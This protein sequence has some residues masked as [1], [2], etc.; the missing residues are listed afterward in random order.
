MT[1]PPIGW[2]RLFYPWLDSTMNVGRALAAAGWP[3][4]VA[5]VADFQVSGRGRQ[6]RVW[7]APPGA[8]LLCSLMLRPAL[9]ARR[10][11]LLS[12][13]AGLAAADAVAAVGGVDAG[14]KWPND[15]VVPTGDGPRY[16]KLGGLL[17]ETSLSGPNI[18]VA[19]LGIGINLTH[20]PPQ[21]PTATNL[22]AATG[23]RVERDYL[24]DALLTA[25][26][27][28]LALVETGEDDLLFAAWRNRL[29]TLGQRVRV[30]STEEVYEALAEDVGRDGTLLVRLDSSE[31][32]R[33][34][35][36][37]VTLSHDTPTATLSNP[38]VMSPH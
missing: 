35:A 6:G 37:E 3:G 36:A 22:L 28:R 16:H 25:L 9:P 30:A 33:L 4:G 29:V 34:L 12:M 10:L 14:L 38:G 13:A 31:Q 2:L 26:A 8:A 19:I 1:H 32:R 11:V 5:I 20:H 24:L 23:R 27:R 18:A 15:V 7:E 21:L 17:A